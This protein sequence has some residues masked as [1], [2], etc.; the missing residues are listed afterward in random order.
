MHVDVTFRHLEAS[1]AVRDYVHKKLRRLARVLDD[2]AQAHVVL[3]VEK[4]RHRAEVALVARN[5]AVN[6]VE[7]TDDMYSAIDLVTDKLER[8]VRRAN[9]VRLA[10]QRTRRRRTSARGQ[11]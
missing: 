9:Q 2:S 10:K 6:G 8:Q 3:S 1:D 4:F 11:G 7:E 5:L